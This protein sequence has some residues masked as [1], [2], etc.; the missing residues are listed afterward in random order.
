ML[1]P[2]KVLPYSRKNPLEMREK[3]KGKKRGD[4]KKEEEKEKVDEISLLLPLLPSS[5]PPPPELNT[6]SFLSQVGK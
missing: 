3:G 2:A 4:R 1:N 6:F 5:S